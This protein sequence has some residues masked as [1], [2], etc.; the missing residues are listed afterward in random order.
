MGDNQSPLAFPELGVGAL[1]RNVLPALR[2][3]ALHDLLAVPFHA[4]I[5]THPSNGSQGKCANIYTLGEA[6]HPVGGIP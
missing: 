6:D 1:G 3:E 2:F 5:N 4:Q